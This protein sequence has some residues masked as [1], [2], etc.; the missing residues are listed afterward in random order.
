MCWQERYNILLYAF[1]FVDPVRTVAA[2]HYDSVGT[3]NRNSTTKPFYHK[4]SQRIT[5][6]QSVSETPN[7]AQQ[8]QQ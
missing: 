8:Q 4:V 5:H 1:D 3:N 7:S 6:A 2:V